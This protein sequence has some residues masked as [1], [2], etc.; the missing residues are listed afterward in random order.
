[1]LGGSGEAVLAEQRPRRP[2]ADLP[3]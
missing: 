2:T 3:R 1:M